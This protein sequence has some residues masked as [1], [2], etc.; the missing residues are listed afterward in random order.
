MAFGD[1]D[2][3]VFFGVTGVPVVFGTQPPTRGNLDEAG[4]DGDV[5]GLQVEDCS[6]VL[7]IGRGSLSPMPKSGAALQVDGRQFSVRKQMPVDDG[8]VVRLWLKVKS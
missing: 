5:I 2:L 3:G 4:S 8:G 1:G 6:H 7:E